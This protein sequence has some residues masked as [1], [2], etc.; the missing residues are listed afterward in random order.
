MSRTIFDYLISSTAK[1]PCKIAF[2]S[3]GENGE[4]VRRLSYTDLLAAVENLSGRL[5]AKNWKGHCVL[6]M[7]QHTDDFIVSFLACIRSG[8][9]PVPV[10]YLK[11]R[12]HTER[13]ERIITDASAAA[14]LSD[15]PGLHSLQRRFS[16]S[17][18]AACIVLYDT[19]AEECS[20]P[21]AA[22]V[23]N[24]IAFIQYTSGST[25]NPKG[26]VVTHSNLLHNEQQIS[27]CFGCES[28]SVIFS[29]LPFYHDMGLIGNLLQTIY[30]GGTCVLLPPSGFMR[31]PALWLQG[32]SRYKATHSGAPDFAYMHCVNK[33]T[34]D[35]MAKVDLSSWKV[36][37]SGA[38]TV[39]ASTIALFSRRFSSIGFSEES[40]CPCY[41]LAEATLLVA[42]RKR[43][44]TRTTLFISTEENNHRKIVL[45]DQINSNLKAVVSVGSVFN[46][47][48]IRII[49][50]GSNRSCEALEEGEICIA[51]ENVT[52]GYWNKNNEAYFVSQDTQLFFRTGDLGFTYENELFVHGRLKEMLVVRGQNYY[53]YDIEQQVAKVPGVEN[54]GI[55]VFTTNDYAGDMVVVVEIQKQLATAEQMSDTVNAVNAIVNGHFGIDPHDILLVRPL[56]IPRTTSGKLQRLACRKSYAAGTFSSLCSKTGLVQTAEDVNEDTHSSRLEAVKRLPDAINIQNYVVSILRLKTHLPEQL[57][58]DKNTELSDLGVDSLKAMDLVNTVKHDL[59]VNIQV[60][61]IFNNNS[62]PALVSLLENL[63]WLQQA[64]ITGKRMII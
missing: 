56:Q 8:I 30:V 59:G 27:A 11:G 39:N 31:K 4:E 37:F 54:T 64:E 60:T 1:D 51:G 10:P 25:G 14:V 5:N 36:A 3:L 53:P 7:F 33:I 12:K 32:I 61:D 50:P 17:G 40:F 45:H 13:L 55:A 15:E 49:T 29:W 23:Y 21:P 34:T 41:G 48:S 6:L 20:L 19:T 24:E 58:T 52:R 38:E 63:L 43:G 26:V 2:I 62:L 9:I 44:E 16:E 46:G 18:D 22:P 57:I 47:T 28:S 42:G 35:D